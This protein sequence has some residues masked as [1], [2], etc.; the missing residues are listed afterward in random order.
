MVAT[1][2]HYGSV[3]LA[4][5]LCQGQDD[6]WHIILKTIYGGML[7]ADDFNHSGPDPLS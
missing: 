5:H 2:N 7:H 6:L 3:S 1:S 4:H